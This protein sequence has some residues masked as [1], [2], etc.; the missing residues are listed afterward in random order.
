ML[1]GVVLLAER[2]EVFEVVCTTVN[3]LL[4]VMDLELSQSRLVAAQVLAAEAVAHER[5]HARFFP[6]FS[7][8][9]DVVCFLWHCDAF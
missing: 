1:V 6:I 4:D 5:P 8:T 2:H 3:S 7:F 9:L